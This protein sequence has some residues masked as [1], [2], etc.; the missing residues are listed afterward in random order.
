MASKEVKEIRDLVEVMG[1]RIQAMNTSVVSVIK[2][3]Q[4]LSKEIEK[5]ERKDDYWHPAIGKDAE[6]PRPEHDWVLV[7]IRDDIGLLPTSDGETYPIPR[8]AE[9]RSD[10]CWWSRE[11]DLRYETDEL[12]FQ[13]VAWRPIPGDC[14]TEIYADGKVS[15]VKHSFE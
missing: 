12:P 4:G 15:G 6:D 13:V 5:K 1:N 14:C 3:L 11:S 7:K 2:S 8:I 10:G 9:F